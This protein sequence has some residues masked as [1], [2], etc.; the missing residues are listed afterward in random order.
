MGTSLN[1][2]ID[3]LFNSTSTPDEYRELLPGIKKDKRK[4]LGR[5]K[6]WAWWAEVTRGCNLRCS[7]CAVRLF[8]NGEL[9]FMSM[10]TWESLI[11][12]ISIVSPMCRLELGMAGEPTLNPNL[13]GMFR[14]ARERCPGIQLMMY[15]NGTTL[16]DGR[17]TY[18][19]LFGA[20]LNMIF[21]DTYH[22]RERHIELA[23]ESGFTWFEQGNR[24]GDIPNIFSYLGDRS[25]HLIQLSD[26]PG[27]W[28]KRKVSG[29]R[30]STYFN[31]LDWAAAASYGLRP[32]TNPPKRRCDLP[33]K[34]PSV[35]WDGSW[36]FCC[37]DFMREVAG[38]LGN[39]SEGVGS[40]FRFWFG[41]YMQDVRRRLY[42]KDRASHHMCSRCAFTS[43][44]CDIPWWPP[45]L[46]N[47]WYDGVGWK[48]FD[49]PP[50]DEMESG[51]TNVG[52]GFK[53]AKISKGKRYK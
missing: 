21:M 39:V 50:M 31:H 14:L 28:P 43:I 19:D 53:P 29:G 35:C 16:M 47:D 8:P 3:R 32:V 9:N 23:R 48:R 22:P 4:S 36:S 15:T 45:G 1:Y 6:P 17:T 26:H 10:D 7:F 49:G 37:F 11:G 40:F 42:L 25:T 12:I 41:R 2:W 46:L 51:K 30:F 24:P 5:I 18:Q 20:G 13:L 27:N 44:R 38:T 52:L 34:F 33:S